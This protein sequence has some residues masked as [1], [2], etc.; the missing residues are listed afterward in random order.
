MAQ[1]LLQR[2][3]R[4][5]GTLQTS[6]HRQA[7]VNGLDHPVETFRAHLFGSEKLPVPPPSQVVHSAVQFPSLLE[8]SL[9]EKEEKEKERERGQEEKIKR[10]KEEKGGRR[11]EREK[12]ENEE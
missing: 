4:A 9:G 5:P 7:A 3:F 6:V 8:G 1:H 11:Q 12:E 10:K 2:A